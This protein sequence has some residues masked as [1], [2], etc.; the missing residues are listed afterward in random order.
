[1][2]VY[3]AGARRS[4]Q[5]REATSSTSLHMPV[6]L[7]RSRTIILTH[8]VHVAVQKNRTIAV[9][10]SKDPEAQHNRRPQ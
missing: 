10:R 8:T 9:C 7:E 3:R 5:L 2:L 1:M 6:R 4:I